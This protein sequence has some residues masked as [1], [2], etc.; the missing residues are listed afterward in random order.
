MSTISSTRRRAL[1]CGAGF[2]L[3]ALAAGATPALAQGQ[4]RTFSIPP[5]S[6]SAA[7]RAYALAADRPLVFS[8]DL[9]RGRQSPGLSGRYE[10]DAALTHLLAGTN[11]GWRRAPGGG[12][13]I[14]RLDGARSESAG[15][16]DLASATAAH[17]V[18]EV[19]VTGTHIRGGALT[20]HVVEISRQDFDRAGFRDIG[21]ALR[22]L[23]LNSGSGLNVEAST[24]GGG[25]LDGVNRATAGQ[26]SANLFGLGSGATLVLIN[27][28]RVAPVG[29]GISPDLSLVPL[30]AVDHIDVLADGASAIYGADAVAGVVNIITRRSFDGGEARVRY[31]GARDGVE[32]TLGSVVTGGAWGPASGIVGVEYRRQGNLSSADRSRSDTADQPTDLFG[33]TQSTSA[34]ASGQIDLG[35]RVRLLGD[36]AYAQR[37]VGDTVFTRAAVHRRIYSGA[38]VSELSLSGGVQAD[39]ARDWRLEVTGVFS[40]DRNKDRTRQVSL[41]GAP[42]AAT[43]YRFDN[44]LWTGEARVTGVLA[45]LPGGAM[46]TAFGAA[47]RQESSSQQSS[48]AVRTSRHVTSA[49][50]EVDVPIVGAGNRLW[51]VD[52][53]DLVAAV[54]HDDYSDFGGVTVPK[55]GL[56]WRPNSDLSLTASFSRSFRAPAPID[57]A[58]FYYVYFA[59]V[60]DNVPG[61]VSRELFLGGSGVALGPE[62]SQNINAA[63]TYTPAALP[64]LKLSLNYYRIKY[65]DRIA[66]PDPTGVYASNLINA[67]ALLLTRNPTVAQIN[68][69]TAGAFSVDPSGVAGPFDVST[70]NVLVD[71]RARN[72]A[73]TLVEGFEGEAHYQTHLAG[74]DLQL[75]AAANYMLHYQEQLQATGPVTERVDTIFSPPDL[76][77]RLGATWTRAV[78]SASIFGSYTADYVDN[79]FATP[80]KVDSWTTVDVSLT[81]TFGGGGLTQGLRAI[82]SASNLFDTPPPEIAAGSAPRQAYRW[83]GAN[84]S[85]IGRF[86]SVELVK[87]W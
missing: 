68:A 1:I 45:Q 62:R 42:L 84:A 26:S 54:R 6:L 28:H 24:A 13:M 33:P 16:A 57:T 49:Y 17:D 2:G 4:A 38:K 14:V 69:L 8:D 21:D 60:P 12:L 46:S 82:L 5:Q 11:L 29:Y 64:G 83:D 43:V 9:V 55:V 66:N 72:L 71:A 80:R 27:G 44:R 86:V 7:L 34:F 25:T 79:R 32:T 56:A 87:S 22:S 53:L 3:A 31:G 40:E 63:L 59:D 37:F 36:A 48:E 73:S 35:P 76:R 30:A 15:A 78:W 23:P 67:P 70:V 18:G 75:S 81:R 85:I 51:L 58:K 77:A 19:V 65:T 61:G 39:L 50:A 74:G 47:Y 20:S 52:G 41:A 10:P